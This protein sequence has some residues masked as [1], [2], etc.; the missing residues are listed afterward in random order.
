MHVVVFGAGSLG[1]LVGGL[2]ARAHEVT[3]V[4]RGEH[5]RAVRTNGL[6]VTGTLDLTVHPEAR[7]DPPASAGLVLVTVKAFDTGDAADALASMDEVGAV[8]SLQNGMGNEETLAAALPWPVLAGTTDFGAERTA[9]GVVRCNGVGE[10]VLGP[11]KG[12][13]SATAERAGEAFRAAAIDTTVAADMPRRLWTKLAVNAGI[14]PL[15][16]LAR[17]DNGA[18]LAEPLAGTARTAARETVAAAAPAGVDLDPGEAVAA[19]EEVARDTADNVSSMR[20]DV[21]AGR[22]TE[23]DAINGYVVQQAT[24]PVPVNRTL[25]ALVGGW[26]AGEAGPDRE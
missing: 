20:Q 17:V 2:L 19:M 11:P 25:A 4:G 7:T 13:E 10:V 9:P 6:R 16:A 14:N 23:I 21:E 26:E 12:G 22:R 8:L 15:T 24:E 1:S 18:V 3:L 5:V